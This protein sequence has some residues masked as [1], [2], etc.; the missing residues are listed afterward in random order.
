[1]IFEN[2]AKPGKKNLRDSKKGMI[3]SASAALF[4]ASLIIFAVLMYKAQEANEVRV[5]SNSH[6]TRM[7][8]AE[9][10]YFQAIKDIY[11]ATQDV[12]LGATYVS[13]GVLDLT[14]NTTFLQQGYL[15]EN[16]LS[17]NLSALASFS[18]FGVTFNDTLFMTNT[19]L[20]HGE[21]ISFYKNYSSDNN[22]SLTVYFNESLGNLG[23]L[24]GITVIINSYGDMRSIENYSNSP[25]WIEDVNPAG[26]FLLN[27]SYNDLDYLD[28][29]SL[30]QGEEIDG[31]REVRFDSG[32]VGYHTWYI[33]NSSR[34][35]NYTSIRLDP[36]K[37]TITSMSNSS[38]MNVSVVLRVK[39]DSTTPYYYFEPKSFR[40]DGGS[41]GVVKQSS[42]R[43]W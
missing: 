5:V 13:E 30:Y 25:L 20:K 18:Y 23:T 26:G 27:I 1:M 2:N 28:L 3:Y 6:T 16:D 7:I 35:E 4:F 12:S 38:D 40:Y 15:Y 19:T 22:Q 14:Y 17:N 21:Y 39:H 34:S 41:H 43:F 11:T 8:S 24:Y 36:E 10:A 37:V 33:T 32:G 31:N 9:T 29:E 42:P